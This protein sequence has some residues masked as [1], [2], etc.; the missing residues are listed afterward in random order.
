MEITKQQVEHVAKLARL[1]VS[2]AEQD[3]FAK[4]LSSILTYIE[5]LKAWDTAGVEPTATVLDQRNVFRDDVVRPSLPV[6]KVLMN[7]P[8][9]DEGC[10]KVPRILEER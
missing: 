8:E 4:Q 10:F 6:E 3:A 2:E 5:Q 7:A 9:A 1:E